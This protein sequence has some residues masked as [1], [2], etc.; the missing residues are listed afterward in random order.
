LTMI[1]TLFQSL[2][3]YYALSGVENNIFISDSRVFLWTTCVSL[4][5]G[6]VMLMWFG[7]RITAHGIGNGISLI[8]F[9]G[10]I[11]SIPSTFAQFLDLSR[12]GVYSWMFVIF[13]SISF[14]LFVSL[15]V[16]VEKTV[17]RIR[18]Q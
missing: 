2:G 12:S 14:A 10:I 15:I 3:V 4:V 18:I 5:G 6:T 16:F 11:S 1:L 9:V 8:I 7:E 13:F 17:R